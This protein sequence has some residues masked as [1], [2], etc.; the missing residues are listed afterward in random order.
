MR[1]PRQRLAQLRAL[2][3]GVG[4]PSWVL[5][6]DD[7]TNSTLLDAEGRT[8]KV[9]RGRASETIES[10][11]AAAVALMGLLNDLGGVHGS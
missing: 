4:E 1:E 2:A 11:T 7:P 3:E 9:N 5:D 10:A 6:P 8:I